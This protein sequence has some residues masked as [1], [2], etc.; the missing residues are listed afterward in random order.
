ML[1]MP[2]RPGHAWR[3]GVTQLT[4]HAFRLPHSPFIVW[5]SARTRNKAW[6]VL[7]LE[8]N[9]QPNPD[10]RH[11]LD[12]LEPLSLLQTTTPF[13]LGHRRAAMLMVRWVCSASRVCRGS[14]DER[15][16]CCH[17]FVQVE[18]LPAVLYGLRTD[19]TTCDKSAS[20]RLHLLAC[21]ATRAKAT[22]HVSRVALWIPPCRSN[23]PPRCFKRTDAS[24][25]YGQEREYK[26]WEECFSW[27]QPGALVYLLQLYRT[28]GRWACP[29][30][31]W[32]FCSTQPWSCSHTLCGVCA[33]CSSMIT[34][35]RYCTVAGVASS[36]GS[37]PSFVYTCKLE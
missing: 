10:L 14:S 35:F 11:Y 31:I 5:D 1:L 27:D 20:T 17:Q 24:A 32:E 9:L 33:T 28:Y 6:S 29:R 4:T 8:V 36:R 25:S 7:L 22:L 23:H 37:T 13:L 2:D 21:G 18:M 26:A 3:Q 30:T 19:F 16:D 12:L 34:L 15:P